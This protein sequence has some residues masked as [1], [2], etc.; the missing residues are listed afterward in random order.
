MEQDQQISDQ[1]PAQPEPVFIPVDRN[2]RFLDYVF[3]NVLFCGGIRYLINSAYL[4]KHPDIDKDQMSY[5]L[6]ILLS[7]AFVYPVYCLI[8]ESLTNRTIGKIFTK[9]IVVTEYG[10][11]PSF[12]AILIRSLCRCVPFEEFSFLGSD[13]SGWHDKWSK[14]RVVKVNPE[15]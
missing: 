12:R 11:K 7:S 1:D 13:Q 2:V 4:A 14:T 6:V 8:A 10:E 5:L 15:V 9:T 3:D